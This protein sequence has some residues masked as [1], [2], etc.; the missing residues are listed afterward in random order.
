MDVCVDDFLPGF[1]A[2]FPASRLMGLILAEKRDA[3]DQ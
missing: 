1:T 2:H 3:A